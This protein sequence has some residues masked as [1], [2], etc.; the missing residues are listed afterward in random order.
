MEKSLIFRFQTKVYN[1]Q[2]LGKISKILE[3]LTSE[4]FKTLKNPSTLFKELWL[5]LLTSISMEDICFPVQ[6]MW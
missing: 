5:Q 6:V 3:Y 2:S 4:K 1:L